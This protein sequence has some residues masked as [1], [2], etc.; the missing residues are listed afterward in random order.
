M[1]IDKSEK[2]IAKNL[3]A[4]LT[5]NSGASNDDSDIRYKKCLIECKRRDKAKQIIFNM[6]TWKKLRRQAVKAN[7]TPI[8]I[9]QC[10]NDKYVL[11][12]VDF[13]K[14]KFN[15]FIV[16]HKYLKFRQRSNPRSIRI[17]FDY[18]WGAYSTGHNYKGLI[19]MI[20]TNDIDFYKNSV[21]FGILEFDDFKR[22]MG[23]ASG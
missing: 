19:P 13:F 10:K 16:Y 5:K 3:G 22:I 1:S 17:S 20:Q 23:G 2:R 21:S 9:F 7:K 11:S 18:F 8:Y 6:A 12:Y 15:S 4:R 14:Q